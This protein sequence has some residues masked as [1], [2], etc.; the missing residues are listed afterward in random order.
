[1]YHL[2]Y[3]LINCHAPKKRK[4]IRRDSYPWINSN[5]IELIHKKEYAHRVFIRERSDLA[6]AQYKRARNDVTA[7]IRESKREYFTTC[8]E[9][10]INNPKGIWNTLKKLLPSK[11]SKIPD[12]I[13]HEGQ[14]YKTSLDK[15]NCFNNFFNNVATKLTSGLPP[16]PNCETKENLTDCMLDIPAVSHLMVSGVIKNLKN[17]KGTGLDDIP[18]KLV[19]ILGKSEVFVNALTKLIDA[20]FDSGVFPSSWKSAKVVPVFKSGDPSDVDNYRPISVLNCLS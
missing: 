1:M 18:M 16:P 9:D 3:Q 17:V 5:V 4:R 10:N 11:K 2:L 14:S 19:K 12:V 7:S 8:I 13:H 20:S 15:A 6:K